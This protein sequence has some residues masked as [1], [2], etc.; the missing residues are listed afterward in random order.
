MVGRQDMEGQMA[1]EQLTFTKVEI[2]SL[3][4]EC[5][6]AW[7]EY[8]KAKAQFKASLQQIAPAGKRVQF[9]E[10]Y[11]ELKLALSTIAQPKANAKSLADFLSGAQDNGLDH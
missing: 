4:T 3:P 10:K 1:R 5:Q 7:A 6:A 11:N 2:E 9:V 8:L